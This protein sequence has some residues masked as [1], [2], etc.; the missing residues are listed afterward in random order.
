MKEEGKRG[1]GKSNT[2]I[3]KEPVFT[4][5]TADE[6]GLSLSSVSG[7]DKTSTPLRTGTYFV[8]F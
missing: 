3:Q 2:T 6:D 8:L 7:H 4:V 1:N 5:C